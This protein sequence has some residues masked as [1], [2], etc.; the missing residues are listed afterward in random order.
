MNIGMVVES[1]SSLWWSMISTTS[2]VSMP[3]MLCAGSLW[4]TIITLLTGL[5]RKQRLVTK[6][7]NSP[8]SIT[9]RP[10]ICEF[11]N[12]FLPSTNRSS[13][14]MVSVAI[15]IIDSIDSASL[16][17]LIVSAVPR[18]VRNTDPSYPLKSTSGASSVAAIIMAGTCLLIA[19]SMCLLRDPSTTI[20]FPISL[21]ISLNASYVPAPISRDPSISSF[22]PLWS[23]LPGM[24]R[25]TLSTVNL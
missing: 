11:M 10:L 4:S 20:Q 9:A 14:S 8:F 2:A 3:S 16:I 22:F 17:L 21:S 6:P 23:S 13:M 19:Y 5:S 12:I 25:S 15:C 18:S 1:E 24:T 7:L